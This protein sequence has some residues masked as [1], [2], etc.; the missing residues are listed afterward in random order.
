MKISIDN[1]KT[2]KSLG[3]L[4]IRPIN[5][6]SGVNSSGKTSFIQFLLLLKQTLDLNAPNRQLVFNSNDYIQLGDYPEIIYNKEIKNS[7][8][9]NIVFSED[10][11]NFPDLEVYKIKGCEVNIEFAYESSETI[12]K[13]LL[14][15]Y[16]TPES[17]R[18]EHSIKFFRIQ[19]R[20]AFETDSAFFNAEFQQI[21]LNNTEKGK[22]SE[23]E[24]L[25]TGFMPQL[26]VTEIDNPN[27]PQIDTIPLKK[28]SIEPKTKEIQNHLESYFKS[29]SYIGPIRDAPRDTYSANKINLN[30][31]RKGEYTA[32]FLQKEA[33]NEINYY[34][35][36]S[37]ANEHIK[38]IETNSTLSEAVKYWICDVFD[39]AKDIMTEEYKEE[40]I[41]NIVNHFGITTTI[42]HV[43]FGLSQVLPIIVEG[44]R[45]KNTGI[46]IL[47]QPEIH[48]HPKIQ[49]HL[50]DFINSLILNGKKI[51]LETHSD[52]LITRMRRRVAEDPSD[53]LAKKINLIFVEQLE[54]EYKFEQLDLTDLGSL[55][56][57]PKDFIEQA[58]I[59][60]RAIVK[61]QAL[62]RMEKKNYL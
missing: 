13:T 1:F 3:L 8:K 61:A 42:K 33:K 11:I 34:K 26:F 30:I 36:E 49:S 32:Y 25:L 20:Y 28:L 44:L 5:I 53:E 52:H 12:L 54:T 56:Y 10:E 50:F 39:L 22:V 21:F 19:N 6:I 43:G 14:L 2:I 41:I 16:F 57:F 24:L 59:D 15:K 40:F 48:L 38:Y 62:K 4:E 37:I 9:C 31:G 35:I 18:K 45:M 17:V 46:L 23:G 27:Y 47:E 60:Y 58:E 29:I 51:I 7:I 55:T